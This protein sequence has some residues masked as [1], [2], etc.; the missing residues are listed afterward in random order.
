MLLSL[1]SSICLRLILLYPPS[2][3]VVEYEEVDRGRLLLEEVTFLSSIP[4]FILL[5]L[6]LLL[7]SRYFDIPLGGDLSVSVFHSSAAPSSKKVFPASV[8]KKAQPNLIKGLKNDYT[9]K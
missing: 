1:S 9:Y 6:L 7:S 2:D 3:E 5:L 8:D 4:P